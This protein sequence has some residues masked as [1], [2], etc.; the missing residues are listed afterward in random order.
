[1]TPV[2]SS[3]TATTAGRP[4]ARRGGAVAV[5]AVQVVLAVQFAAGGLLK[6]TGD[7]TMVEMFTDIG[8]GQWLRYVVGALELAGALGLLVPRLAGPAALGIVGLM[9]GAAVTN[10]AVLG[11]SPALPLA[12][13][14]L[15]AVVA[16]YRRPRTPAR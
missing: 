1:M 12:F 11:T 15:G 8:A 14:L 16:W 3:A 4:A 7:G 10:V 2:L 13:L 6:I 5:W 9:A